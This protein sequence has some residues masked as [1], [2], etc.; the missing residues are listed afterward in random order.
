MAKKQESFQERL[1]SCESWSASLREQYDRAIEDMLSGKLTVTQRWSLIGT[2][3][4]AA[5]SAALF[6][7]C[8][9]TAEAPLLIRLFFLEG[10]VFCIAWIAYAALIL[11]RGVFHR[12]RHPLFVAGLVWILSVTL[13]INFLLAAALWPASGQG[14]FFVGLGIT[15]LLGA[16]VGLLRTCIEQGELRTREHLLEMRFQLANLADEFLAGKGGNQ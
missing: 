15:L 5:L 10:V 3:L 12:R 7:W 8:A 16:G 6:V 2:S 13:T 14:V 11:R 4:G 1:L 9:A